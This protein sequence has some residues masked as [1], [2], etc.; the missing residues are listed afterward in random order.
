MASSDRSPVADWLEAHRGH[1]LLVHC[2][3]GV[4]WTGAA[5]VAYGVKHSGW[6]LLK[7]LA[8]PRRFGMRDR[9]GELTE[10]LIR[11]YKEHLPP[12]IRLGQESDTD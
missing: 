4:N 3:A 10:H 11:C 9:R 7:A 6:P 8:E 1:P 5:I 2:A 12:S